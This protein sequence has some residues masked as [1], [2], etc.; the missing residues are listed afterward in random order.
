MVPNSTMVCVHVCSVTQSCL[1]LC[2]PTAYIAHYTKLLCLW[3]FPEEEY[4][5]G[6]PFPTPTLLL[7]TNNISFF[8]PRT[9][10]LNK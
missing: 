1:T 5:N 2:D 10:K 7:I 3:N 8:W 6:L 9:S 4:W